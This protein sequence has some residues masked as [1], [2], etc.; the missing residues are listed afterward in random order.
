M[1]VEGACVVVTG[2]AGGIGKALARRFVTEGARAVVVSDV[3]QGAL[4]ATAAEIGA[5]AIACD[6]TDEAA[7]RSLIDT[8]EAEHGPIDLFCSNAGVAVLGGVDAPY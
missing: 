3:A 8:T 2:G 6:V 4:E 5:I 1:R 7:I